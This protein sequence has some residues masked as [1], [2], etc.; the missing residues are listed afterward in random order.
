MNQ[1][2][3]L[4][5]VKFRECFECSIARLDCLKKV[6][7]TNAAVAPC[8]RQDLRERSAEVWTQCRAV[9]SELGEAEAALARRRAEQHPWQQ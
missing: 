8:W 9:A 4:N 2:K 6:E 3:D 5:I 7:T 1:F